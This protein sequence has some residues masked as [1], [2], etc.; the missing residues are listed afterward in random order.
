MVEHTEIDSLVET[1][2]IEEKP[3]RLLSPTKYVL[4]DAKG[5]TSSIKKSTRSH[6]LSLSM[7]A[8]MRYL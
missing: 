5:A 6:L 8:G 7:A 4:K 1:L 3:N 2:L